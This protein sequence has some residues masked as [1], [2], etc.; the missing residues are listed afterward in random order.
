M[1]SSLHALLT[2]RAA[3]KGVSLNTYA[4]TLL[5]AGLNGD[6]AAKK[7]R[8]S[9]DALAVQIRRKQYSEALPNR[10]SVAE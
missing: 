1:P 5:A 6:R 4:V 3:E 10:R 9:F 7:V 2:E 8:E